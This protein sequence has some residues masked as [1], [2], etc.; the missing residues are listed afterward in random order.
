MDYERS[1]NQSPAHRDL[2][3]SS[4]DGI[5]SQSELI[6]PKIPSLASDIY[7]ECKSLVAT[8]GDRFLHNLMPLVVTA[9]ENLETTQSERDELQLKLT[10]LNDDHC[11]LMN[12]YEREKAIRKTAETNNLRLEDD[13][14]EERKV[15]RSKL[16][17]MEACLRV[18]ELKLRNS[19]EQEYAERS[20]WFAH[21]KSEPHTSTSDQFVPST[22]E[23]RT[24]VWIAPDG[25]Y[26]KP[27]VT[28]SPAGDS[29]RIIMSRSQFDLLQAHAFET[30]R[31][32]IMRNIMETTPELRDSDN[33]RGE[34]GT[35]AQSF[36]GST[37]NQQTSGGDSS[38]MDMF[39]GVTREVNN[40]IKENQ[41]LVQTK[42]ALN[43]VTNDL[44]G[45]IDDLTCENLRLSSERNMLVTNSTSMVLRIKEL[46][47]QC[48]RLRQDLENVDLRE[49]MYTG[50][51]HSGD[52][53]DDSDNSETPLSLRKRFS[54][55][56]M[57]RVLLERNQYK[58]QL[59]E[60]QDAIR[61]T[62][63]LKAEQL[64]LRQRQQR[65][66]RSNG[67][68][69]RGRIW[70]LFAKLFTPKT[71]EDDPQREQEVVR[72]AV[73]Y[74]ARSA[75]QDVANAVCLNCTNPSTETAACND[76]RPACN[77]AS[78]CE[79]TKPC[80][81]VHQLGSTEWLLLDQPPSL[82][83]LTNFSA[84]LRNGSHY[85]Y[86][87]YV[88]P[89]CEKLTGFKLLCAVCTYREKVDSAKEHVD[90]LVHTNDRLVESTDV[91]EATPVRRL[92]DSTNSEPV[93]ITSPSPQPAQPF[94]FL[95]ANRNWEL[96][97]T[98][99]LCSIATGSG[100]PLRN[101]LAPELTNHQAN[102]VVHSVITVIDVNT[103]QKNLDTFVVTASTVL[104]MAAVPG[105]SAD[106]LQYLDLT[107]RWWN[108][109]PLDL[110][111]ELLMD[112]SGAAPYRSL[113]SPA[114]AYPTVAGIG[115]ADYTRA[116]GG[117]DAPDSTDHHRVPAHLS[118]SHS[119][120]TSYLPVYPWDDLDSMHI[121]TA[122]MPPGARRTQET[123]GAEAMLSYF[124]ERK[125]FFV[126]AAP[127]MV[128]C[129][130]AHQGRY[131]A[132]TSTMHTKMDTSTE[133]TTSSDST[134]T[135]PIT[136]AQPTVW[137]GCYSG[138]V[139]VHSSVAQW[140]NCLH[141]I[142]LPDSVTQIQ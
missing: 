83:R 110:S 29:Q 114:H 86:T 26:R 134:R 19:S 130:N 116:T 135:F 55:I 53:C 77:I 46:E 56:E 117:C 72:T 92:V 93:G 1:C 36:D 78:I 38:S 128:T 121:S 91:W 70:A 42:N 137:L 80:V 115:Q 138:D 54:R 47:Q 31:Q 44:I 15:Y 122:S 10:V 58:E 37:C 34:D 119:C 50:S 48:R 131:G 113:Y 33:L 3:T 88:R 63:A 126:K 30:E 39:N 101:M 89:V 120:Q 82:N 52:S 124:V 67:P 45:R 18:C 108:S 22:S 8:Y 57:A 107:S 140:R 123:H 109:V 127:G 16:S 13:I 14:E 132:V 60:L 84:L 136:S 7:R 141:A 6:P 111:E 61:W 87:C 23:L 28:G 95:A 99:W 49:S 69:K 133:V 96:S 73:L 106:D 64:E 68:R 11:H 97:N 76:S 81:S 129:N 59:C 9:L 24:P 21:Q 25:P 20:R 104:C 41:D 2:A 125:R 12:E 5:I 85:P 139:F 94:K 103:P 40:L 79:S 65:T 74:D 71:Q 51:M 75:D 112:E 102:S 105:C 17:E 62:G 142:R 4:T 90:Q 35:D 66:R 118:K 32:R 27:N 100:I 98:I 43:V